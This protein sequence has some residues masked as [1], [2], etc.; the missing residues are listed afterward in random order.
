MRRDEEGDEE[1]GDG[2]KGEEGEEGGSAE[3]HGDLGRWR[4]LRRMM[5]GL[6][7][8]EGGRN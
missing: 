5:Q 7:A 2:K 6:R 1:K 8:I 4:A 3:R